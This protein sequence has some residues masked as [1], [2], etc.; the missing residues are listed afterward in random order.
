M[1]FISRI[2]RAKPVFKII[3]KLSEPFFKSFVSFSPLSTPSGAN[4]QATS[5]GDSFVP[6]SFF[7]STDEPVTKTKT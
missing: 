2:E 7:G 3:L 6:N 4:L 5:A 1:D